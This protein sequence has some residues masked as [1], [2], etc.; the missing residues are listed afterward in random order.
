MA[1]WSTKRRLAYGGIFAFILLLLA[2]WVFFG[3]FYKNP[4]CTDRVMNGDEKGVDCGGSCRSLC[5]SDALSPAVIWSEIFHISGDVYNAV[6]YIE[7]PNLNSKN[8]KATYQ[9]RLFDAEN[10]LITVQEGEVSIP[11]GKKFAIFET[12]LVFK[13]SKPVSADFKFLTFSTW[14]RDTTVEPT[15]N[16][17]YGTVSTPTTTPRITGTISNTSLSTIEEV[18]LVAFV[19]DSNQNVIAA[20]RTFIDDLERNA[21][22]DFVFTWQRPFEREVAVTTVI[23]RVR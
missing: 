18:E 4:T 19:L 8:S 5:T 9:F 2:S 1:L 20:S 22:Q 15:V 17:S 14:E 13:N 6:A 23:Y 11:K 3:L 10:K 16:L 12:G 7:N 21:P